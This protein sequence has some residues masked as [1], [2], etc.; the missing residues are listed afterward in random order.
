M[1]A[2]LDGRLFIRRA[3]GFVPADIHAE[4]AMQK[5]AVGSTVMLTVRRPRNPAHHRKLFALFAVV[6]EQ[7]D[8]WADSTVLLE[9]L[10]LATGLFE[11]RVSALT[12]MPYPVPASISFAAMS[13]DRFAAWYEKAIRVLSEH[14]GCDVETLSREVALADAY[15]VRGAA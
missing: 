6:L 11:T 3:Q 2:D 15:S 1:S 10:K 14:L 13:Q 9:D 12:G 8:R 4:E 7:T 5:V